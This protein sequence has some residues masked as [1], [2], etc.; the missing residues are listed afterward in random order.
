[1]PDQTATFFADLE[2]AGHQPLLEKSSGSLRF[3][4]ADGKAI[5]RW[6]VDVNKGDVVVSRKTGAADCVLRAPKLLFQKI[7]SGRENAMAA[8]L[9]G[10]LTVE[11]DID[12]LMAFQRILPGPPTRKARTSGR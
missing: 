12:L 10:A 7:A 2:H 5:E 4:L 3:E 8:V 11:G 9:R 6:R 1:M